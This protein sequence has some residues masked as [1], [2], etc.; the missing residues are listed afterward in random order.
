[1]GAGPY[2]LEI[3]DLVRHLEVPGEAQVC[4]WVERPDW[5][6]HREK[7]RRVTGVDHRGRFHLYER[8]TTEGRDLGLRSGESNAP[9]EHREGELDRIVTSSGFD[10]RNERKTMKDEVR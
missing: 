6:G 2:L 5:E 8:R 9:S 1:V 3:A 10:A 7:G 4:H